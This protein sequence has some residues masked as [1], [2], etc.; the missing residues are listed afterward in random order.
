MTSQV[1]KP[2]RKVCIRSRRSKRA[3][4][5]NISAAGL[6]CGV[7]LLGLSICGVVSL[8]DSC[9]GYFAWFFVN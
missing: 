3:V 1:E 8:V 6:S 5:K 2:L 7:V 4:A 9:Y